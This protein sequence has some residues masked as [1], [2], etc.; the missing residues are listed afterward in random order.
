MTNLV[1]NF[2]VIDAPPARRQATMATASEVRRRKN[3]TKATA[4][5][6]YGSNNDG[7]DGARSPAPTKKRQ[8]SHS[9]HH[10]SDGKGKPSSDGAGANNKAQP[11]R[12]YDEYAWFAIFLTALSY[13]IATRTGESSRGGVL[14]SF[15]KPYDVVSSSVTIGN[16]N[17]R[18]SAEALLRSTFYTTKKEGDESSPLLTLVPYRRLEVILSSP[19]DTP[20]A[21]FQGDG[22]EC[23]RLGGASS[24]QMIRGQDAPI[25]YLSHLSSTTWVHDEELGRGY[26]L[27]ADAG[28]SG[29]IWRWEVGGGPITIG[30]S[31]HME[32]SGCRS[33][34]WVGDAIQGEGAKI[35]H[36]GTLC[37]ENL[38]GGT[39]K[40]DGGA[41]TLCSPESSST[42]IPSE[43]PPLLGTASLAV[44]LTRNSERASAGK[45]IIVAEWGERR[46]VRVE[47]E[48]GARTPLVTLV[49]PSNGTNNGQQPQHPWRRVY[50]PNHLSYTPFGDLIFTDNYEMNQSNGTI[51]NHGAVYRRREA[52]HIPP[53]PVEQSRD[54]HGWAS[55][56]KDGG[57]DIEVDN[58][59]TLFQTKNGSMIEG[60]ALGPDFAE[61]FILVTTANSA[62]WTKTIYK[63]QL[64]AEDGGDEIDDK[65]AEKNAGDYSTFYEM[66]SATCKSNVSVENNPTSSVGSKLT[67]DEKG[68]IY[69]I[70]CPTSV[71][72][73]DKDKGHV[74]GT[75]ALDNNVQKSDA[76]TTLTS[77]SFG[78]D[79]YLYITSPR[80]L[81]RVKSR[82]GGMTLPTD[83]V[84]PSPSKL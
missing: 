71:S 25:P 75:L 33:G 74:I 40:D 8:L 80:D 47:G 62:G 42:A 43:H 49:P 19:P 61:L 83:L 45:N 66:T 30:R 6:S 31:L 41:E 82:V 13:F 35:A 65:K 23:K 44:E 27:L 58:I 4:S 48:T 79:G 64:S 7:G 14:S 76:I 36:D 16:V 29:R 54:A 50:R 15:S 10:S 21:T 60:I 32:R 3:A 26:L 34:L 1:T 51:L 77:I 63:L 70:S 52:V 12:E 68:T 28:R 81:M 55:T 72:L 17:Q 69:I 53:I 20:A 37:P 22:G 59:D 78:E 57:N 84:V 56:T 9:H 39:A 5:S 2:Y 24:S 38:F 18:E 67:I 73:L 46:I 11:K